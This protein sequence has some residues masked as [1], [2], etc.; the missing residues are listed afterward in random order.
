MAM[1][2]EKKAPGIR[3]LIPMVAMAL[4]LAAC[5]GATVEKGAPRRENS[6]VAQVRPP[7]SIELSGIWLQVEDP[8]RLG[9][10]VQFTPDN[11]TFAIDNRGNLA[12]SPA[13]RG[14]YELD[15]DTITFTNRG[16]DLCNEG[17]SWAW[18][19]RLLDEGKLHIVHTEEAAGP[20][21]VPL[22]TEW[23]LVRLSPSSPAVGALTAAGPAEGRPPTPSELAGIWF[24]VE[25]PG[26]LVQLSTDGSFIIDSGG[27]L[28]G[29]PAVR[30]THKMEGDR[31]TFSITGAHSCSNGDSWAWQ[32]RLLDEGKLHIVHT[33]EAAGSCRI[34]RGTEW[35]LIRVSPS[36]AASAQITAEGPPGRAHA[37]KRGAAC[38]G[39]PR[40]MDS[41]FD[42]GPPSTRGACGRLSRLLVERPATQGLRPWN[43]WRGWVKA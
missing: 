15:E 2:R 26:L 34:R 41:R 33:E 36:S 24:V 35:T 10:L 4:V 21:R 29:G 18:Q 25:A 16:S 28:A 6:P 22:R 13:G 3:W 31:I 14:T 1:I 32:A 37:M 5:G 9:L 19:A 43:P 20:C 39:R 30:G 23:T 12:R 27:H 8:G 42:P 17:D 40:P 38:P 7:T 11:G